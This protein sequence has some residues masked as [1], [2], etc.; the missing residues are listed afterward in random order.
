M[1]KV[2]GAFL[3]SISLSFVAYIPVVEGVYREVIFS[4]IVLLFVFSLL[5]LGAYLLTD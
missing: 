4:L 1:K 3:I 2:L 5:W